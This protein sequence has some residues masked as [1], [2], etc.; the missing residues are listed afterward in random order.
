MEVLV[1]IIDAP[2]ETGLAAQLLEGR[3]WTVRP[4]EAPNPESIG[5]GRRGL[6]VEVRLYGARFGAV[7]A[8]VG[9]IENL[10]RRHQA[11]MWVVDAALIEHDLEH[12][13][14]TVFHARERDTDAPTRLFSLRAVLKSMTALRI[15]KQPGRP[16]VQAVA[17]RLQHGALTGRPYDPER[18]RL[19]IPT[20]MEGR[21]TDASPPDQNPS[22]WRIVLPFMSGMILALACGYALTAFDG[23]RLLL[24]LLMAMALTWPVGRAI[25]GTRVHRPVR[26][27]LAWGASAVGMM[28]AFGFMLA[29]TAPGPP[30]EVARVVTY[31]AMGGATLAFVLYG[32]A[33]ALVHSWFSRNAN[34]AIPVLVPALALTL[35][36]FGGLIHTVYLRTGFD[37]PTDAAPTSLYW[38]YAAA[39]KPMGVSLAFA[40][41]VVAFA[42]WMRHYHQWVHSRG[43]VKVGVPLLALF[44]VSMSM[45]AGMAG[46][47]NA[48]GRAWTAARAGTTPAT[49]FGLEGSLV[50]VEPLQK[51]PSVFN[52][53]LDS[54]KPLLTFGPSGDRVW[55]WDPRRTESLSVRLEDVVIT[56]STGRNCP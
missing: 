22:K 47:E 52:G 50:C 8:A 54:K 36:W 3:G 34:W 4:W 51:K 42:G 33:Y 26:V 16:D 55:L 32:L 15:V 35:P 21:D 53:P 23:L 56:E 10:A 49:Y 28:T 45:L 30:A 17:D 5:T 12:D 14:R 24:P 44:I 27:Q 9:E 1:A 43:M 29:V 20:G 48:A 13:Y 37:L 38:Q 18:L 39:L 19:H 11:G 41:L 7:Q 2:D 46:A 6:L 25:L 40:L 31:A